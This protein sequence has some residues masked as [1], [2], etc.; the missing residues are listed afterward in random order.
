LCVTFSK[1]LIYI[2]KSGGPRVEPCGMPLSTFAHVE[3]ENL[4]VF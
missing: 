2:R 1:S 4:Y 3:K